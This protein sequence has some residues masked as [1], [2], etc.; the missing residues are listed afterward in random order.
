MERVTGIEPVTEA[1]EAFVIPFHHTR[2][3]THGVIAWP[4][5]VKPQS[6]WPATSAPAFAAASCIVIDLRDC[7]NAVEDR[8]GLNRV[9]YV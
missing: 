9:G 8:E 4:V 7:H 2:A 6:A 5:V 1:W 3:D